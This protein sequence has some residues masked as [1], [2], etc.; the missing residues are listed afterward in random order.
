MSGKKST[1]KST[2][3]SKKPKG[4]GIYMKIA[5]GL[6]ILQ[7]I[8]YTWVHLYLSHSAGVEIAPTTSIGFYSFCG[9][10]VGICGWIKNA[11]LK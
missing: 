9:L 1:K 4:N 7:V 2:Q 11:K 5:L 3:K 10:E 8:V 6:V